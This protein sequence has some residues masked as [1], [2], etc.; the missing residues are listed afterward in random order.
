[1]FTTYSNLSSVNVSKGSIVTTGFV[2]G[3]AGDADDGS[4]GQVNFMLMIE[5]NNVNPASWLRR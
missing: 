2:I 5:N 1:Y 4:G 3:R